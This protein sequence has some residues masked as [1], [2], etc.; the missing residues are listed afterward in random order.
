[1]IKHIDIVINEIEQRG[2]CCERNLVGRRQIRIRNSFFISERKSI[3]K[4]SH[5][6]RIILEV[7]T[8]TLAGTMSLDSFAPAHSA[9]AGGRLGQTPYAV[10]FLRAAQSA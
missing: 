7:A 9:L 3:N 4:V 6:L 2:V 8:K 1:L 10:G 5:E